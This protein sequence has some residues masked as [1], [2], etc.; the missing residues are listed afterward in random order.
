M[1]VF[2]K[3]GQWCVKWSGGSRKFSTQKE[4]NI[5][6]GLE[7]PVE[8]KYAEEKIEEKSSKKEANTYKQKTILYSKSSS[9]KKI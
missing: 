6:A 4:A 9:K 2:E 3:R 1:R 5:F 7:T 8:T